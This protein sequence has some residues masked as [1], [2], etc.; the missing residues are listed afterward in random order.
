M[1]FIE[2]NSIGEIEEKGNQEGANASHTSGMG[3]AGKEV[4][5]G[6]FH[7]SL[8][9]SIIL[10]GSW[11]CVWTLRS[12]GLVITSVALGKP[13]ASRDIIRVSSTVQLRSSVVKVGDSAEVSTE[14][15]IFS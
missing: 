9:T 14:V 7:P 5:W 11:V 3:K 10:S 4:S 2:A 1:E 15:V 8:S 12:E 13:L 6:V